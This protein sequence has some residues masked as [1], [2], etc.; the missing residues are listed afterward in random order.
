MKTVY[1]SLFYM[2]IKLKN[3]EKYDNMKEEYVEE[4]RRTFLKRMEKA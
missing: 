3:N 4:N 1:F 2:K